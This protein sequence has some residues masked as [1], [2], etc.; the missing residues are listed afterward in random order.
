[1]WRCLAW[2]EGLGIQQGLK[3]D[4]EQQGVRV[5]S[6]NR[7][8][9]GGQGPEV[10]VVLWWTTTRSPR[11]TPPNP[12]TTPRRAPTTSRRYIPW[13]ATL[14]A[15]QSALSCPGLRCGSGWTLRF[16]KSTLEHQSTAKTSAGPE[17]SSRDLFSVMT[18]CLL[19]G[20]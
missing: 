16:I 2:C 1:M 4:Q 13:E 6:T 20:R 7:L 17:R 3:A 5:P 10:A 19:Q 9:D 12:P 14:V 15:G 8:M 11:P 18:E